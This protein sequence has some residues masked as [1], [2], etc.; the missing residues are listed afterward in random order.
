MLS[1]NQD[2][3]SYF[4]D[5]CESQLALLVETVGATQTAIYLS[6][7]PET[8]DPTQLIPIAVYPHM[9]LKSLKQ[10]FLT[11]DKKGIFLPISEENNQLI[12]CLETDILPFKYNNNAQLMTPLIYQEMFMGLLIT[13]REDREW[14]ANELTQIEHIAQ[15]IAIACLLEHRQGWYQQ[16]LV[17][18]QQLRLIEQEQLSNF[19]HQLRNPLTALRTFGK[20]LLKRLFSDQQN[21]KIVNNLL[22]ETEHLQE[23]LQRFE[24]NAV[25]PQ[26]KTTIK[27]IKSFLLPGNELILEPISLNTVIEDVLNSGQ[28]IAEAK[29]IE[30]IVELS[31]IIAPVLANAQALREIFQN[32]LDNALKYTPQGG[33]VK[34]NNLTKLDLQGIAIHD[35]GCGI[36]ESIQE[37]IFERNYR[38]IQASGD[39]PGT[40]LGL[41]IAKDLVEQMQGKIELISPNYNY[42][43]TQPRGPGTTFIVWLP[44]S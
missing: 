39:I 36:P 6:Q 20:L 16:N 33:K 27:G 35:T 7:T 41:A 25:K 3:S 37:R 29:E 5:L 12:D 34:I 4:L 38:G 13:K 24:A 14:E 15:T 11:P 2:I 32:L 21:Q 22:R 30:I 18:M 9:D 23:L 17:E 10:E 19:L 40:G 43:N 44:I 1:S 28:A 8:N 31:E 42:F 26:E